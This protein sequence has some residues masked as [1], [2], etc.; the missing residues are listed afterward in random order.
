ML[1]EQQIAVYVG[2][3][4]L[5]GQQCMVDGG[6]GQPKCHSPISLSQATVNKIASRQTEHRVFMRRKKK[7]FPSILD[8]TR[9][10]EF[11]NSDIL[12]ASWGGVRLDNGRLSTS[13]Q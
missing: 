3:C 12:E 2:E 1:T 5:R 11:W 10:P 8:E 4:P 6:L 13:L 7:A 9:K